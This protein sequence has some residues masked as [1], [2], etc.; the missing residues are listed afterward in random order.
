MNHFDL[1]NGRLHCEDV[2][3]DAIAEAVGTP[4]F[5][6]SAA[7][8]RHHYAVYRKAFAWGGGLIA[9]AVKANGNLAV[10]NV[11]AHEGAGADTVSEGEIRRA[12]AAG[13]PPTRIIFSGMGKTDRE[14]RFA[15]TLPEMQIN[16]ESRVE[17]ERLS[18]LAA[19][20]GTL[21]K[22]VF[23]VNPAV[24]AG[25][26]AK[27]TTGQAHDKFGV[28]RDEV[29][30]L[31]R[32]AAG[33][34]HLNPVGIGCHIG[35]QIADLA[36]FETA[37]RIM[38]ALVESLRAEGLAVGRLDLGGGLAAP[39]FNSPPPPPPARLGD[40]AREI[41]GDLDLEISVEPGRAIAA[42]AGVLLSR[43]VHVNQRASGPRFL[44]LDA[45]MNDLIRPTLY[46]AFHEI[47]PVE[48]RPGEPVPYDVVG[49]VCES[50][51]TFARDRKLPPL[52]AGDLVAFL[53]A[54]AYGA[55]MS[56]EYN[57]RPLAPEVLVDG[58][59]WAIVRPRPTIEMMLDREVVPDWLR[60]D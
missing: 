4:V 32:Q 27:I 29:V 8:L 7:T 14:L 21:P 42:N 12:L 26:H 22:V 31:Y 15:L 40:L 58:R 44:V 56:S 47:C 51:D 36:P 6:Y 43:V 11:L 52:E 13:I 28:A 37:W 59:R 57:S 20:T 35:S 1:H 55:S 46:D 48:S 41:L 39:Y 16:V 60:T 18:Q 5:V 17:L 53:S 49:P 23:R 38:R 10:L 2:A 34:P 33:D 3:L 24:G 25:A 54:G 45:A 9:Y 19:E 50:G 30:E